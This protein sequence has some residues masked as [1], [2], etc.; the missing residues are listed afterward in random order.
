M[1]NLMST[2]TNFQRRVSNYVPAMQYS[3]DVHLGGTTR[4]NFGPILAANPTAIAN[5]WNI[6]T[7]GQLNITAF[8]PRFMAPYGKAVS[9]VGSAPTTAVVTVRG[10][11]YLGQA[12]T[13]NITLNGVTAVNGNKAFFQVTQLNI[14]ALV[15]AVT[16]N[17]GFTIKMGL[18]YKA[19]RVAYEADN[20]GTFIGAGTLQLPA[21][22]FPQ[23]ATSLDPRGMFT[24]TGTC[25]GVNTF[26]AGFDM[27]NDVD[28]LNRGGLHGIPHFAG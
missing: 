26:T 12:M 24:P 4:V 8:D 18:P 7:T 17:V 22:N 14:S 6:A 23:G 27:Y 28:N 9:V 11:D 2:P 19:F 5:A 13:E 25:N 16:V 10:F 3:C 15:P 1:A 21:V 20:G